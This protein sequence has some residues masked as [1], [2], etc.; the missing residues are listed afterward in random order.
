MVLAI[1]YQHELL[2]SIVQYFH[3]QLD[4]HCRPTIPILLN[5]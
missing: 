3:T 5:S 2:L 1:I 4:N